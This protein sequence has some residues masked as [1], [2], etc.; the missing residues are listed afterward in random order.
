MHG[1]VC[2]AVGT[3]NMLNVMEYG[4]LGEKKAFSLYALLAHARNNMLK[5]KPNPGYFHIGFICKLSFSWLQAKLRKVV[6]QYSS[7]KTVYVK[8]RN[9]WCF[10]KY[11]ETK[12]A[13]L[14]MSKVRWDNVHCLLGCQT[15]FNVETFNTLT[16][17]KFWLDTLYVKEQL[18]KV[19]SIIARYTTGPLNARI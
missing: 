19:H 16:Q 17:V 3:Q 13:A 4:Y 11:I 2:P 7:L 10:L 14:N 15:Q 8:L 12:Q 6:L 18:R 9:I 5:G 1:P